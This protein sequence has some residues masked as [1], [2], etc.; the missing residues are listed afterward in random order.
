MNLVTAYLSYSVVAVNINFNTRC[1]PPRG[2][3]W[4]GEV[5]TARVEMKGGW[6]FP[7][8]DEDW[9]RGYP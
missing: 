1:M 4:G 2:R 8:P 5:L 7:S 3:S 6:Q 9:M